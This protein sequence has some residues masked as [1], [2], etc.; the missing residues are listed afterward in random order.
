M[1]DQIIKRLLLL[2]PILL[3][4]V[5]VTFMIIHAIPGNPAVVILGLDATPENIAKLEKRMGLDKPL[6]TQYFIYLKQLLKG[7]LG[8]SY[9]TDRG[10]FREIR[11]RYP[12][13]ISLAVIAFVFMMVLGGIAGILCALK[14]NSKTDFILRGVSVLGISLP[15]FWSGFLFILLFAVYL[16][17]FPS[18]GKHGFLSYIL[19]AFTLSLSGIGMATRLVRSS[20]LEIL[21]QPYIRAARAKGVSEAMVVIRHAL[22]NA[23]IPA[24][25]VMGFQLGRFLGGA[26]VVE[27]VFNWPGMGRLA[28]E[29]ILGRD[30]PM[31]QATILLLALTYVIINLITD[32]L[33]VVLDPRIRYH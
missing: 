3:G 27:T 29:A 32:L 33:Y 5:L 28:V 25:T 12:N 6:I 2:I 11:P 21:Q 14:Q 16:K 9:R 1:F 7:D 8:Y 20:L 30:I 19:P 13:T 18:E 17:W 22:K 26:V 4:V 31:I 23:M 15:E 10:V 24:I